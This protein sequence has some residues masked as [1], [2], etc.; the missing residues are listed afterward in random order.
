MGVGTLEKKSW[1]E[2]EK[3]FTRKSDAH[4]KAV[5]INQGNHN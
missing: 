1:A 4:F 5:V 2:L 3:L